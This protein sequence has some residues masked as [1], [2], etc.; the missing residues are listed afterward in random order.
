M[1]ELPRL[2]KEISDLTRILSL[3]LKRGPDSEGDQRGRGVDLETGD[4]FVDEGEFEDPLVTESERVNA[5]KRGAL[6]RLAEVLAR[7]KTPKGRKTRDIDAKHVASALML[8]KQAD[9][10][11]TFLCGKNEGLDEVDMGFLRRL[12]DLLANLIADGTTEEQTKH[13]DLLYDAIF[14]HVD[15]RVKYYSE[16]LHD[17]FQWA[18]GLE[19]LPK[20]LTDR[21]VQEKLG[22]VT[23]RIWE[24]DHGL[25]FTFRPSGEREESAPDQAADCMSAQ[26]EETLVHEVYTEIKQLFG[27][28]AYH[29]NK[30]TKDLLKKVYHIVRHPRQRPALK[31]RLRQAVHEDNNRFRKAWDSLLYMVRIFFAAVT[32]RDLV[33]TSGFASIKFEAVPKVPADNNARTSGSNPVAVLHSLGH[34]RLSRDWK[35]FSETPEIIGKLTQSPNP[36]RT[37]HGEVQLILH[38]DYRIPSGDNLNGEVFPY[39]GCSKK[40]CFFC[41]L[42]LASHGVFQVRG[43][44]RTLFPLWGLTQELTPQSLRA[45]YQ[46]SNLLSGIVRAVLTGPCP[47]RQGNLEQQSSAALSSAQAVQREKPTHSERPLELRRIMTGPVFTA[48]EHQVDFITKPAVPGY[49]TFMGGSVKGEMKSVPIEE[50]V[51]SKTN[52]ERDTYR[53]E[54]VDEMPPTMHLGQARSRR[55]H[56]AAN[57]RCSACWTFYCSKACQRQNWKLHVFVCR[58]PARPNDVDYLRFVIRKTAGGFASEELEQIRNSIKYVLADDQLCRTFGFN[59]CGDLLE[60]VNLVC[61]YSTILSRVVQ[62]ARELQLDLQTG[63][64]S[65]FLKRFCQLERDV[66]QITDTDECPCVTWFLNRQVAE[67]FAIPNSDRGPY[68]IWGNAV[69]DAIDSLGLMSRYETGA[70]FNQPQKDVFNLY[71]TLKS[72][73]LTAPDIHSS[74]WIKFGFCL[75][76]KNSQRTELAW[77]YLA[78][79]SSGATFDDIV[80][81][82]ETSRL[83][84]LMRTHNVDISGLEKEGIR[85][86]KP[87]PC[88]YRVYRLMIGVEHALS[89]HFCN[90]FRFRKGRDFHAY[91]ETHLDS[92]SDTTFGVHLTSSWERWQLLNFYK[93]LFQLPG[94]DPRRMAEASEDEDLDG[95]E[96]YLNSLVPDMRMKLFDRTRTSFMF[97]RLKDRLKFSTPEGQSI[98]H[99][100]LP[101][102]CKEHDVMGP[103]GASHISPMRI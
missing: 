79:A 92:E 2:Q 24:D 49:A 96:K 77:K 34:S 20:K 41:E 26:E 73:V 102:T 43:T 38:A 85:L 71:I 90:C 69:V 84:D 18:K 15:S 88:E 61:L 40:C 28:T 95:L 65:H 16:M 51:M 33:T 22:E 81:A 19:R 13:V 75:C 64:L 72:S 9:R 25:T 37:V 29:V 93:Y 23:H 44:H 97:P 58:V 67:S 87:P 82:Y 27:G 62:P 68:E 47:P 83:S 45:L 10:S 57:Y 100:H 103:P 50:A 56:G 98:P 48:S 39:I 32:F 31:S 53:L 60:V 66:A 17:V 63:N 8:E 94:F 101:C 78:L 21:V 91:Y 99:F 89:G 52:H 3:A 5:V 86:H 80:F 35:R 30:P 14:D 11:V 7:F 76:R 4:R 70:T 74:S 1:A 36:R 6:D 59:K 54:K 12:E 55:C 46:F 42:F